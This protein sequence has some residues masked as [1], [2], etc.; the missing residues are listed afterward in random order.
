MRPDTSHLETQI[1]GADGTVTA[2]DACGRAIP[3][4]APSPAPNLPDLG[5]PNITSR[6]ARFDITADTIQCWDGTRVDYPELIDWIVRTDERAAPSGP[7]RA[8]TSRQP[9]SQRNLRV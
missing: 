4:R 8:T 6:N 5:W 9:P 2:H 3:E 1:V 7:S